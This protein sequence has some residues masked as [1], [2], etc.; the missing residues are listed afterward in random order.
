MLIENKL[1][2]HIDATT[3]SGWEYI[4]QP[5]YDGKEYFNAKKKYNKKKYIRWTIEIL[6]F[7]IPTTISIIAL[8]IS[9]S[10]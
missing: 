8:L 6:K 5:T 1:L 7:L 3:M 9:L 10:K 4:I 2:K